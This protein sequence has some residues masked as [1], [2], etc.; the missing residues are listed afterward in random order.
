VRC[1]CDSGEYESASYSYWQEDGSERVIH[2]RVV[3]TAHP[4]LRPPTDVGTLS[5]SHVLLGWGSDG[6]GVLTVVQEADVTREALCDVTQEERQL[7]EY[8][9]N[10]PSATKAQGVTNIP[11][12]KPKS[13]TRQIIR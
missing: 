5:S 13:K 6:G 12:L 8:T 3:L 2:C 1:W 4:A 9:C 7:R 10:T 11:S